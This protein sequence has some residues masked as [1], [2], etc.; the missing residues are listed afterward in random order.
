MRQLGHKGDPCIY[1]G[2]DHDD[3]TPGPCPGNKGVEDVLKKMRDYDLL[4][5]GDDK[6]IDSRHVC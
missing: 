1:C 3:V 6:P 5:E 4:P 2:A